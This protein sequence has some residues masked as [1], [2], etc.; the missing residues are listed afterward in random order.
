MSHMK[1]QAGRNGF[2]ASAKSGRV[3]SASHRVRELKGGGAAIVL[4]AQVRRAA[5]QR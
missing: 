1:A 4:I 2:V 5:T 3:A